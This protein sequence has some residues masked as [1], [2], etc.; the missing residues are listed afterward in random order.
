M[1]GRGS[2]KSVPRRGASWPRPIAANATTT[3]LPGV[4][5]L[6]LGRAIYWFDV[7]EARGT[8]RILAVFFGEQDHVRRMM[9][10]LLEAGGRADRGVR[11]EFGNGPDLG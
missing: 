5:H 8:V 1:R 11:T 3:S 6:A 10:R 4:R 2:S 7:D 9:A